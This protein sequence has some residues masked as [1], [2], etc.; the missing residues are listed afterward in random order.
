MAEAEEPT[1]AIPAARVEGRRDHTR[2]VLEKEGGQSGQGATHDATSSTDVALF[3]DALKS[4]A[5]HEF[6]VAD[7]L[8]TRTRQAIAVAG[9]FFAIVQTV[10]FG[11]LGLRQLGTVE[12]SWV[13]VIALV[14][15]GLLGLTALASAYQKASIKAGELPVATV[16]DDM[17]A[18][19]DQGDSR[20]TGRLGEYYAGMVEER[21]EANDARLDRYR[22]TLVL[23]IGTIVATSAELVVALAARLP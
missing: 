22:L 9:I 11:S 4:A 21:R 23:A 17:N 13:I 6:E 19:Y 20:A 15:V 18:L 8:D 5:E 1:L 7:R 16:V 12:R 2:Q 10:V 14:A 3:V